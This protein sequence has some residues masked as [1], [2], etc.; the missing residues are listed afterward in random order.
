[1]LGVGDTT[2]DTRGLDGQLD[3]LC[4]AAPVVDRPPVGELTHEQTLAVVAVARGFANR[5]AEIGI[6]EVIPI[7]F[8]DA[9]PHQPPTL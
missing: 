8:S 9:S 3:R 2:C 7:I 1:M 5:L 6:I 4:F